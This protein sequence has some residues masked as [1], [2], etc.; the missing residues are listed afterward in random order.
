MEI[1]SAGHEVEVVVV[2]NAALDRAEHVGEGARLKVVR[3]ELGVGG[4]DKSGVCGRLSGISGMKDI[5]L[6]TESF[7]TVS[8][9]TSKSERDNGVEIRMLDLKGGC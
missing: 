4:K 1:E 6:R 3:V 8:E 7:S 2:E 5:G 9:Y